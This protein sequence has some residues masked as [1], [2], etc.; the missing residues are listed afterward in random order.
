M[1]DGGDGGAFFAIDSPE[2]GNCQA[3]SNDQSGVMH[4]DSPAI[5]LP[6]AARPVLLFDHYVA[7]EERVDG[8]NL[9]I[10]VNGGAFELVSDRTPSS[11]T[12]T[13]TT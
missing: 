4:L 10:S 13:T 9:K 2:L 8:G 1:P 3:G 11:S 12:R 5:A 6:L 7:T